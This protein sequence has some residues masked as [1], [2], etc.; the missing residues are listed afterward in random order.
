MEGWERNLYF[1]DTGLP[2]VAPS[3]NLPTPVSA[4]VYPGQV[5]WEGT[6]ISEGRGT[7]QPFE[8]FGAPFMDPWKILE[9]MKTVPL[10]GACLRPLAFEPTFNKHAG[11]CCHGFQIHITEPTTY[12][13]YAT[14]LRLLQAIYQ[15]FEADFAWSSPPYEYEFY[16]Q[17][18]DLIFGNREIRQRIEQLE[19]VIDI[20]GSWENDVE[21]FKAVRKAYQLYPST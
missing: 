16:K 10:P 9:D 19:P 1:A 17:P 4:L 2:W 14:S 3:P 18:I 13:P 6:N 12:Q 5:I 8:I 21:T 15:R 11:R 7:T 20:I